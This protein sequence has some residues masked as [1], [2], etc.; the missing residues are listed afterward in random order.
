MNQKSPAKDNERNQS[1]QNTGGGNFVKNLLN[2]KFSLKIGTKPAG[3]NVGSTSPREELK[4]NKFK[5]NIPGMTA[6]KS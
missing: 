4:V 1:P 3:V 5:S 6:N 2:K